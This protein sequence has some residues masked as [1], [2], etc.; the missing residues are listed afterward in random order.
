MENNLITTCLWF[1][2]KA[3]QA[4]KF[5]T[6]IFRNSSIDDIAYYTS[7][8]KEIHGQPEGKVMTVSFTLDGRQFTGLNGGPDFKFTEAISL[9]INVDNQDEID[10]YWDHLTEGGQ[11]VQCGWLKDKYGLSWQVV[12]KILSRMITD[13]DKE[14]VQRVTSAFLK[15][16]KFNIQKLEEAFE[17]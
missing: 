7:E 15:M 13:P 14:K 8:G 10:Y 6:S 17:G 2:S 9:V 12:P 3:E 5:Y 1:D 11:E 4:A 16:K